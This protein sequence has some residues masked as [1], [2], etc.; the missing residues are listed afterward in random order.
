MATFIDESVE[1]ENSAK[2]REPQKEA[3]QDLSTYDDSAILRV[4][5]DG[6]N[7]DEP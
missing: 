6:T 1:E 5:L 4:D 2:K 3:L 7:I